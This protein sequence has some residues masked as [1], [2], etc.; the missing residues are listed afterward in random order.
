MTLDANLAVV[1]RVT[2]YNICDWRTTVRV[3][4]LCMGGRFKRWTYCRQS[5]ISFQMRI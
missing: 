3:E 2:D 4:W 5:P 1:V